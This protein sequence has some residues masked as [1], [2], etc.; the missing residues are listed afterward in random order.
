MT[1]KIV[2]DFSTFVEGTIFTD[3]GVYVPESAFAALREAADALA[4]AVQKYRNDPRGLPS[5]IHDAH[6][7]Y[8]DATK[9]KNPVR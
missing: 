1:D 4:A 8:R 5:E 3:Q 9:D 6:R 2:E 7:A